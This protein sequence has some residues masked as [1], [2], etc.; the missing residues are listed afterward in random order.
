VVRDPD[1][2]NRYDGKQFK[3][4]IPGSDAGKNLPSNYISSLYFDRY[5]KLLWIGTIGGACIYDMQRDSLIKVT[6]R[7]PFAKAL[8]SVPVKKIVSF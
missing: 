3:N 6:D 7:Y 2:L 5:K 8:E 4:Y 1:G